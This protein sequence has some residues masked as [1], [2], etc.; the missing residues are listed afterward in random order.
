MYYSC[1]NVPAAVGNFPT[2]RHKLLFAAHFTL[3][4]ANPK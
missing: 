1:Q 4:F 3:E 2:N